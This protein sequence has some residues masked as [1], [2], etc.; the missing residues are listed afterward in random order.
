MI[1]KHVVFIV[2]F[3]YLYQYFDLTNI[4]SLRQILIPLKRQY[5]TL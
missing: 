4:Y 2:D 1:S 3:H 5:I